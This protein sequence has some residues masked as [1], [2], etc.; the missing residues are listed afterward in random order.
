MGQQTSLT[1]LQAVCLSYIVEN[2]LQKHNYSPSVY[3]SYLEEEST[4]Q[5]KL[6]LLKNGTMIFLDIS[7]ISWKK[8]NILMQYTHFI[9][10]LPK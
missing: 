5:S 1:L 8:I 4:I 10:S 6:C 7:L 2:R 3:L 9:Q